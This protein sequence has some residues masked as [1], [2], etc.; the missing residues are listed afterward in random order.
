MKN[1]RINVRLKVGKMKKNRYDSDSLREG[2]IHFY[3]RS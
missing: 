1:G 2:G 3:E